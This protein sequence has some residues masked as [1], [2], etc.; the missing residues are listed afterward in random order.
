MIKANELRIGNVT[1]EGVIKTFWEKGV[2]VGFGKCYEFDELNSIPLTEEILL[3][4]GFVSGGAKQWLFITLDK[5]DEC[6]LYL[7]PLGKGIAIDQ[8][9]TECSF[10]IEFKYVHQLQNIFFS[11]TNEELTINL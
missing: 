9:G 1:Q 3:K 10:E 11:L 7:N 8:N 4:A 6:Y 5:K 2:H